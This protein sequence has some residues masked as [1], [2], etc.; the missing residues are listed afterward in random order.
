MRD[1]VPY[2]LTDEERGRAKSFPFP[3]TPPHPDD[4]LRMMD[5]IVSFVP[6]GGPKGI[7]FIEGRKK[8]RPDEWFF[9]AHFHQDPVWPGSLG[10]EAMLQLMGVAAADRWGSSGTLQAGLGLEHRWAYRGQVLPTANEVV[11]QANVTKIDDERRILIADG[12]LEVD[13]R[14]IYQ[15]FDFTV[16]WKQ[17]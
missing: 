9:K 1:A 17:T 14:T 10:L 11:V 5:E 8:V 16:E 13:G 6:N 4:P 7:G 3:R 2:T 15:M 12:L